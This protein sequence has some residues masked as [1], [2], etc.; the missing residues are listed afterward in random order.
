MHNLL[1]KEILMLLKLVG[2]SIKARDYLS[3]ELDS[4]LAWLIEGGFFMESLEMS[5][6]FLSKNRS[7]SN[8]KPSKIP[9]A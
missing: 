5:V 8:T 9:K 1:N 4:S 6:F 2:L 3:I 7:R